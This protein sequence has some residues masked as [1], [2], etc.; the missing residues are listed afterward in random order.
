MSFFAMYAVVSLAA[1]SSS[2][3]QLTILGNSIDLSMSVGYTDTLAGLGFG[4]D[5]INASQLPEHQGDPF[6]IILGGQNSPEGIGKIV[7]DILTAKDKQDIVSSPQGKSVTVIPSLWADR[8]KVMVFAGYGK[9]QTRRAFGEAQGDI[10]KTL[11][12]N[13]SA[14]LVLHQLGLNGSTVS[15]MGIWHGER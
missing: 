9:E 10:I 14:Y 5:I 8:Q 12:F 2:S 7:G 13:D 4:V 1:A 11:V 6:L 15:W 3:H